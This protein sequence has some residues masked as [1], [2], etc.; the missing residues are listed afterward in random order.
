MMLGQRG[1]FHGGMKGDMR[2]GPPG[3]RGGYYPMEVPRD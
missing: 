2:G 3:N 1:G